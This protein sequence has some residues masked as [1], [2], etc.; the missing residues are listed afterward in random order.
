MN[1]L[2]CF[3]KL[4]ENGISYEEYSRQSEK[5]CQK[6]KNSWLASGEA[7][8]KIPQDQFSQ[9]NEKLKVLC[10]AENWCVD[11]ANG[12]PVIARLAAELINW[13]FRIVSRDKFT[14]EVDMFYRTAGRKK[15]PV[16][17]F[18][19]SEGDEIIRWVERPTRNYRLLGML[20]DQGLS[21]EEFMT[22]YSNINE[23]KPPL[24]SET[25]FRELL[26]VAEKAALIAHIHS[27]DR[28]Y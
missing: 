2:D 20:R 9:L 24:V 25:I 26:V 7:I 22:R 10:I 23:F 4:F 21:K 13:D 18:T 28:K 15:I 5:F 27:P 19:D 1:K 6:M 16:I 11:C 17:V 12:V 14:H 3:N 8:K